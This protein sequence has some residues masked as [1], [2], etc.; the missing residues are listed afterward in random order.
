M[1]AV[2]R[3]NN[4]LRRTVDAALGSLTLVSPD[5]AKRIAGRAGGFQVARRSRAA[6]D[7][8]AL[9][10]ETNKA[11]KAAFTEARAAIL[12]FKADAREADRLEAIAILKA[13]GDQEAHGAA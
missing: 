12:L 1:L 4:R 2:V 6:R 3:L 9:A 7:R 10:K 13:R 11:A 8:E 5:P